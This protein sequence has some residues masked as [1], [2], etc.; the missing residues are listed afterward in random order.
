VEE[1][2]SA[3]F[4]DVDIVLTEGFRSSSLPKIEV[5]RRERSANL[6]CRGKEHDPMLLAV[7]SDEPL[8]LDVPQLDIDDADMVA[9]FIERK[10]L[11]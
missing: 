6:L 4:T 7:A 8:D 9:D 1:L 5:H 11:P 3:F 2:L 10:F